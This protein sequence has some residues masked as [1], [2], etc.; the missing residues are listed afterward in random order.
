M[1]AIKVSKFSRAKIGVSPPPE[2]DIVEYVKEIPQYLPAIEEDESPTEPEGYYLGDTTAADTTDNDDSLSLDALS[3]SNYKKAVEFKKQQDEFQKQ[4]KEDEKEDKK[5]QKENE[6]MLKRIERERK[7][8]AKP[9]PRSR[10]AAAA[11]RDDDNDSLFGDTGSEILGKEKRVLLLKIK[12][13][14]NL[15]P[16]ELK[17][18]KVKKNANEKEL[19]DYLEEMQVIIDTGSVESFLIEGIIQSIKL[20]EG[21]SSFT[22]NYNITGLADILK[23]NKQFHSLSKQLFIKYG[24]YNNV[25]PEYQMILLVSTTAW[26]CR[27]KNMSKREEI[28]A[29][30]NQPVKPSPQTPI[31]FP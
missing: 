18:F 7:Q 22:R 28:N 17:S 3:S 25:P 9:P 19:A 4:A 10:K 11:A 30:L 29:V 13:Y 26:V 24:C 27:S 23:T 16:D 6:A 2:N 31:S 8:A 5:R 1:P 14:K 20:I 12:Q 21:V 15:F